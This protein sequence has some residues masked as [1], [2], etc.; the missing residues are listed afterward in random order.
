[1]PPKL[2]L[3][4]QPDQPNG[5]PRNWLMK[6]IALQSKYEVKIDK[7]L[8]SAA[9]SAAS[10]AEEQAQKAA[11]TGGI[12]AS[13]REAQLRTAQ[14]AI[15]Q[16]LAD[17]WKSLGNTV[18]AGQAEASATALGQSFDWDE[19]LLEQVFP[20]KSDRDAMRRYLLQTATRNVEAMIA[21]VFGGRIA[22]SQQVYK[23]QKLADGWVDKAVNN[24]L[25]RGASPL[26]LARDV[27]KF[28]RPDTRGGV[29]YA[30]KRLG[31][32]EINTAYHAQSIASNDGKPWV[33]DMVWSLS[34][35]HP[36][37][38]ECDLIADNGPYSAGNVPHKPH[39]QCLCYVWPET[40]IP[41]TFV[42]NYINGDYD[43]WLDTHYS[44]VA[45]TP[46]RT[47]A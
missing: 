5:D 21:R 2:H 22:L 3:A 28:I 45:G 13:V 47:V 25:A 35:S 1:M 9:A 41:E 6:Y 11:R 31:R 20:K 10:T 19:V 23:T 32:T 27:R 46:G 43:E 44:P 29:S 18:K 42:D 30:A 24:A 17:F 38:D 4:S 34:N 40:V 37:Y 8:K 16:A 12:G 36:E 14:A 26:E 15:T 7:L 33:L 39:P